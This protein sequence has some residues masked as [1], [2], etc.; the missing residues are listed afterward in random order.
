MIAV[1]STAN[2]VNQT[3]APACIL[4]GSKQLG[5]YLDGAKQELTSSV[6]GS[7]RDKFDPGKIQRCAVCRFAFSECR[8]NQEELTGLY[9]ELDSAVYESE[10]RGRLTTA[11]RHLRIVQKY[12]QGARLLDV[13][14]ASGIFLN[15]AAEAGW[16]VVGV[17]PAA[18]L[19][20][21]AQQL[22][23]DRGQVYCSP[24]Q[25]VDL[26]SASFDVVTLWD[27]LEHVTDP[28]SFV[29]RCAGLL[30]PSG[31]LFAN[32]P[33]IDSLQARLLGGK[34][35][36]L[37]PEH[38]NYFAQEGLRRCGELASLE[39]ISFQ[40]RPASFSIQYVLCRLAQHGIPGTRFCYRLI[41]G[42]FL[43][44]LCVPV[45]LGETCAVWKRPKIDSSRV[46][47]NLKDKS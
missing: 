15:C 9:R 19:C 42:T 25:D 38:L 34:W 40:Q 27:V 32:V 33:N 3:T 14:C 39:C 7:S 28:V 8:P 24:L 47:V 43:G 1:G 10:S 41:N 6:L 18:V 4:C 12:M 17:E 45:L 30:R 29:K 31:Y 44:G 20:K 11:S 23:A 36:L 5:T 37:L 35:P 26:P 16:N 13:G 22:L 21:K 46:R 2:G